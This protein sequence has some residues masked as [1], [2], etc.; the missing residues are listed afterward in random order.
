[1]LFSFSFSILAAMEGSLSFSSHS[2][3]S[4][5]LISSFF[6]LGG[7]EDLSFFILWETLFLPS[8]VGHRRNCAGEAFPQS[9]QMTVHLSGHLRQTIQLH[10]KSS[11]TLNISSPHVGQGLGVPCES[12]NST[13]RGLSFVPNFMGSHWVFWGGVGRMTISSSSSS[14]EDIRFMVSSSRLIRLWLWTLVLGEGS[15]NDSVLK[16]GERDSRLLRLLSSPL[17]FVAQSQRIFLVVKI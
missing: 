11:I 14:E 9:Q 1:M 6:L 12:H 7:M 15:G 10:P 13:S 8:H 2:S 16:G 4:E 5:E 3:S 17:F